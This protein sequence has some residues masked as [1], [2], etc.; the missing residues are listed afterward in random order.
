MFTVVALVAVIGCSRRNEVQLEI[1]VQLIYSL[2]PGK[3]RPQLKALEERSTLV[4]ESP[5]I[6]LC[7]PT[8]A[9]RLTFFPKL[10]SYDDQTERV[11]WCYDIKPR[12]TITVSEH[13]IQVWVDYAEGGYF[14]FKLP[15][16]YAD[17]RNYLLFEDGT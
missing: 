1:K 8:P 2:E 11:I 12:G 13:A 16:K 5:S 4:P 15:K 10:T 3:S 7:N 9:E 14:Y 17:G 6:G